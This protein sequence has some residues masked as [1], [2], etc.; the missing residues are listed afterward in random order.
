MTLSVTP[1][2]CHISN[3]V[4]D[5]NNMPGATATVTILLIED[6]LADQEMTRRALARA[7]AAVK[8][9]VVD[10]G[11]QG[12][13]F[14][15]RRDVYSG[16]DTPVVDLVLLDLNLPRLT[17]KDVLLQIRQDD[18]VKHVPLVVLS[19]S[20]A[21]ED[22]MESYRLGANSYLVKPSRF[23]DFVTAMQQ[24]TAYWFG[25]VRLPS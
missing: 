11:E 2:P 19:T 24:L 14:L 12:M 25:P 13:D 10:D 16:D 6:N 1:S 4:A 23:D 8:L 17:G 18:A 9:E 3:N 20:H 7:N 15:L 21:P 5:I 22:I